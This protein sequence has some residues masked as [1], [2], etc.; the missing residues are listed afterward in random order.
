VR[1]FADVNR[2][3]EFQDMESMAPMDR[4]VT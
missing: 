4:M 2:V 3:D 1:R